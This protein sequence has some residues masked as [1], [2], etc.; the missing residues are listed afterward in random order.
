M[1]YKFISLL[2]VV[3]VFTSCVNNS[4]NQLDKKNV[5]TQQ[6]DSLF[7][8]SHSNGMFNGV[9]LVAKKDVVIYKKSFG[10]ANE[11]M[12]EKITPESVFYIASVSKQF[13]AMGIMILKEKGK[14]TYDD[15]IKS[16][17]PNYP[18]YLN[19]ITIRQLLNHTSGI[20]DT[21][22]YKLINPGNEDVLQSLLKQ[23][24]LELG[25]G[26]TFRYSN[27]GYVML[28]LIIEKVSEKPID[29]F[30][31]QEIFEP[32]EM[33]NTTATKTVAEKVL[34]KVDGYN[35]IGAKVDYKSS[36]IGPGGIYSTI[37]DLEKWNKGLNTNRLITKETLNQAFTNGRLK[38]D[39]ISIKI[40]DQ[41][42]GYGFGWMLYE[43]DGKKYVQHDG[44][45]ESYR[46]LIKKNLTDGYDYIFLSNQGGRIAMN[47]LTKSI[48]NILEKSEFEIPKIPII[49]KIVKEF[50]AEEPKTA[51][52]KIK[53]AI[54]KNITDYK[55]DENSINRLAYTYLR[56]DQ[57][58]TA[59]EIFKLNTE[60]YSNSSNAFDSLAEGYF[61]NKQFELSKENYQK[62]L[63]LN[64]ENNN[65]KI[66]IEHIEKTVAKTEE[67]NL[68]KY[69]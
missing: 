21:E 37:N 60:L 35:L 15:K 28:A 58:T 34:K 62:S 69:K 42:Y 7:N 41:D 59:L 1:K 65:A 4:N 64:P 12:Y 63:E 44:T 16:F 38:E 24:S 43:K 13:T 67:L 10:Y 46:S 17:F 47:Q 8:F 53:K 33:K 39:S 68:K 19:D 66:M 36:V 50:V 45:V 3:I 2:T 40:F 26:N 25:N 20:M 22:Y 55:I 48:D 23:G 9:V 31:N 32:L 51:I 29:Q 30:F 18:E 57:I 27:S 52:T 14:I 61:S 54:N 11:E 5:Q 6:L 49:N 56:N